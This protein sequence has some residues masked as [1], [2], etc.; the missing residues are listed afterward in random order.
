M[1]ICIYDWTH[2]YIHIHIYIY[3]YMSCRI[4]VYD[5]RDRTS[6]HAPKSEYMNIYDVHTHTCIY[7]YI[8]WQ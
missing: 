6:P 3:I 5:G 8:Q 2:M 4:Y 7:I 1:Y